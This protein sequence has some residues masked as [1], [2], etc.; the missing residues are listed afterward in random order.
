M[1]KVL[2]PEQLKAKFESEGKTFS[3]WAEERGYTRQDVYRVIN[4]FTKAKRGKAH[5]IAVELGLKSS[6]LYAA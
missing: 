2:T 1:A 6:E 5:Q 3:G 4:G